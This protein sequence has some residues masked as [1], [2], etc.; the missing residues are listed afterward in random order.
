[1]LQF[2]G[3]CICRSYRSRHACCWLVARQRVRMLLSA[4]ADLNIVYKSYNEKN[5]Q[6]LD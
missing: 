4:A 5:E 1:M 2:N 3:M 6:N